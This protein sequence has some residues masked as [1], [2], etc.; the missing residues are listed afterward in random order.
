MTVHTSQHYQV[1]RHNGELLRLFTTEHW[2]GAE[3]AVL[4]LCVKAHFCDLRSRSATSHSAL[5]STRFFS[6]PAHRYAP[7]M[8]R[9]GPLRSDSAPLTQ[10]CSIDANVSLISLLFCVVIMNVLHLHG[11][12]LTDLVRWVSYILPCCKFRAIQECLKYELVVC[13]QSYSENNRMT[14]F[15]WDS[16]NRILSPVVFDIGPTVCASWPRL[17]IWVKMGH[18]NLIDW[19]QGLG[20]AWRISVIGKIWY[21]R[22]SANELLLQLH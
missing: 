10:T 8:W 18:Q 12:V 15:F 11:S 20:S 19:S 5:R 17:I 16:V 3:W 4:P 7:L 9:F 14:S 6:T 2:S 22:H 1:L 13:R 21:Y